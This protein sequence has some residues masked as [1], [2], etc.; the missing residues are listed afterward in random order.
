M[1]K[2][3]KSSKGQMRAPD[4]FMSGSWEEDIIGLATFEE[5]EDD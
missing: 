4:S 3:K 2:T 5:C 1:S